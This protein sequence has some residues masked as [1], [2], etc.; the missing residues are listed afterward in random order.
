MILA[1]GTVA[2]VNSSSP[3]QDLYRAL[4]GGGNNFGIVTGFDLDTYSYHL[5]RGGLTVWI[6]NNQTTSA[7][8]AAYAN[9][10]LSAPSS[11]STAMFLAQGFSPS[12]KSFTWAAGL[13]EVSPDLTVNSTAPVFTPFATS[14]LNSARVLTTE[15]ITNHSAL[16]SELD[17]TQPPGLRNQF[18]TATYVMSPALMQRMVTIFRQEVLSAVNANISSDPAF[19]PTLAFQPLTQ[20]ILQ[21][22]KRRGGNVLGLQL[23]AEGSSADHRPLMLMNF[24]WQWSNAT[25][26]TLVHTHIANILERS[27][28]AA[29]D[30]GQLNEYIY[31]NYASPSQQPVA[32]YGEANRDFMKQVQARWDPEGVF[33]NLVPG[34]FKV[35]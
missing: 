4:R 17:A 31:M 18:I 26:D 24:N 34:G 9:Y 35:V 22:Q 32:S 1:D 10:T 14:E 25:S 13:Y 15:R 28:Q 6:S 5:M 3:Y 30:S 8:I 12:T 23:G 33:Q 20:N 19:S 2:Q 21:H 27:T 7:L 16:A 11:P 29:R